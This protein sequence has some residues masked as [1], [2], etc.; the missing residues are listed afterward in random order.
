[1]PTGDYRDLQVW[2]TAVELAVH[3]VRITEALPRSERFGYSAQMRRAS[4]SIAANIAEGHG[5]YGRREYVRFLAIA[6]GSLK[7]LET[8][9]AIVRAV[10]WCAPDALDHADALCAR[11]GQMLVRLRRAL[12][13]P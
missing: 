13:A 6:N 3:V 1:M 5:R 12:L 4:G 9:L 11:V 8:H 2:R 7:E 10:G